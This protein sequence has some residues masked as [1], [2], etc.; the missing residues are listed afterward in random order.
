MNTTEKFAKTQFQ[1]SSRKA[2]FLIRYDENK[3]RDFVWR[4]FC[5]VT[6]DML[7]HLIADLQGDMTVTHGRRTLLKYAQSTSGAQLALLFVLDKE[8]QTLALL[9]RCG[10]R[11]QQQPQPSLPAASRKTE[12]FNPKHPGTGALWLCTAY[13]RFPEHLSCL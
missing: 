4:E 12:Q 5:M 1:L 10:R 2:Y 13:A 9:E 8:H 6:S 3:D 7:L 11:P